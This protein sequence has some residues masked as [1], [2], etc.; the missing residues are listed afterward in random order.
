MGFFNGSAC[1]RRAHRSVCTTECGGNFENIKSDRPVARQSARDGQTIDRRRHRLRRR[2]ECRSGYQHVQ[3]ARSQAKE[4]V[5]NRKF[6]HKSHFRQALRGFPR[7][8]RPFFFFSSSTSN[9]R[10]HHFRSLDEQP[11][12]ILQ[13][14]RWLS[15]YKSTIPPFPTGSIISTARGTQSS[16][17]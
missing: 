2:C 14:H 5:A 9:F 17:I 13:N 6:V 4:Y 16:V 15:D 1:D 8:A 7:R 11:Q 3:P 10:D 12:P